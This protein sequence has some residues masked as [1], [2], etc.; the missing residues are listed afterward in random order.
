MAFG[1]KEFSVV[2]KARDEISKT[3]KGVDSKFLGLKSTIKKLLP[4]LGVAGIAGGFAEILRS[5]AQAGDEIAKLSTRIGA[6]VEAL[7]EYKHVAELSAVPFRSLTVAWQR[8]T[9]RVAEAARG[10][11]EAKDAIKELGLEASTLNQMALD[12]QFETIAGAI[13]KVSNQ[14]DRVRLAMKLWDSEGVALLQTLGGGT[15]GLKEMREE[16]RALGLVFSEESAKAAEDFNDSLTRLRG[17]LRGITMFV[18][19]EVIPVFNDFFDIFSGEGYDAQKRLHVAID[20]TEKKIKE[21]QTS[22]AARE[23]GKKLSRDLE[24]RLGIHKEGLDSLKQ[25]LAD[26]EA[27]LEGHRARLKTME[28][29][30]KGKGYD[31]SEDDGVGGAGDALKKA[32]ALNQRYRDEIDKATKT[33][34]ELLEIW[35]QK[36]LA[37]EGANAALV[38]QVVNIREAKIAQEEL[39]A[40]IAEASAVSVPMFEQA[41]GRAN[42]NIIELSETGIPLFEEA[43]GRAHEGIEGLSE[44]GETM[45]GIWEAVS[46]AVVQSAVATVMAGQGMAEGAKNMLQAVVRAIAGEAVAKA[47]EQVAKGLEDLAESLWPPNPLAAAAAKAHFVSAAKWTA[48]GAAVGAIASM[49][50]GGMIDGPQVAGLKPDERLFVGQT[51]EGVL[52]RGG[53]AAIGGPAV[54]DAINRGDVGALAHGDVSIMMNNNFGGI[55]NMAD[56]GAM[57]EIMGKQMLTMIREAA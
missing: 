45:Q 50:T 41:F 36:Q 43:L 13:T 25:K 30:D 2:F 52:S 33:D 57:A 19:N 14:S 10:T 29:K 39:A 44:A 21:L 48:T 49:H 34:R 11:G 23:G 35:R 12:E 51:R 5:T 26:A 56:A 40:V 27:L 47:A 1:S 22:I 37:T 4:A 38:N 24:V 8:Q 15:D 16:A 20:G 3:V 32:A 42:E 31:L 53:V 7:S 18:G 28:E 6:S 17:R 46:D 54:V 9:R 55:N